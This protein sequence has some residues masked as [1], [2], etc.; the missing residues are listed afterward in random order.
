MRSKASSQISKINYRTMSESTNTNTAGSEELENKDV[1]E[2]IE[3]TGIKAFEALVEDN[4]A[5]TEEF[6]TKA[7]TIFESAVNTVKKELK[8]EQDKK[9]EEEDEE[10]KKEDEEKEEKVKEDIDKYLT[11]AVENWMSE[12]K[13]AIDSSLKTSLSED[14]LSGLR[15]LFTEHYIDVPESKVDLLEETS[16]R[17][18]DL[19][20]ALEDS[21][22][23]LE[24]LNSVIES[25]QRKEILTEATRDLT[26]SQREKFEELVESV[27]FENQE[28]FKKKVTVLIESFDSSATTKKVEKKDE[29][30]KLIT[31]DTTAGEEEDDVTADPRMEAV[32]KALGNKKIFKS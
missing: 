15:N 16:K 7:S 11:Y 25:F 19:E 24:S 17:A 23:K 3:L 27:D 20:T 18:D 14:F 6:K 5:F 29:E 26:D 2:S 22:K 12:N 8:E 28:K 31:E 9:K 30:G 32:L 21:N 1:T 4:E 13:V 10:K